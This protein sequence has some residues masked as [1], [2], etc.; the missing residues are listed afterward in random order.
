MRWFWNSL[1]TFGWWKALTPL[2]KVTFAVV[3]I[4][5]ITVAVLGFTGV[6]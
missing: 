1:R 6:L 5:A 3:E 2:G 4:T